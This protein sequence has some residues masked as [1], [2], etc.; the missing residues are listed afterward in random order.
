MTIAVGEKL[1]E[2]TFMVPTA[3]GPA[4]KTT[5]DVFGGRK[6]VLFAVPGAFTPTCHMNHLPGFLDNID[7]IK[8]KGV[9][10]VVCTSVNDPFV[11]G[12]WSKATG[13]DGKIEMLSDGSADFAKA[14][15]LEL[16]MTPRG[17]GMRSQRYAMIVDDGVVTSLDVEEAPGSATVSGAA[18]VMEKL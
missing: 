5:S 11:M 8:A 10:A 3:D 16:D 15:G 6:V 12:A 13:A 1:P 17:F 7:A 9:D 4:K 14:V 2:A 18:A